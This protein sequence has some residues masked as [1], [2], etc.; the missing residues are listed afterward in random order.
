LPAPQGRLI[1]VC[2]SKLKCTKGKKIKICDFRRFFASF[3]AAKEEVKTV[4][5]NGD[6]Y[7]K[8]LTTQQ[9]DKQTLFTR[10]LGNL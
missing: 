5:E 8:A 7:E 3:A 4:S 1:C 6:F 2:F 10:Y 9:K